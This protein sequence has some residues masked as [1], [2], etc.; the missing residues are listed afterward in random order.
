[1]PGALPLAVGNRRR[2]QGGGL[3]ALLLGALALTGCS[4]PTYR[5][6]LHAYEAGSYDK[7]AAIWEPL[8]KAG[9]MRAQHQLGN[10]YRGG[11]GV[12]RDLAR[13]FRWMERAARQGHAPSQFVAGYMLDEGMG[14]ARDPER[15]FRWYRLAASSLDSLPRRVEAR[16]HAKRLGREIGPERREAMMAEVRA[17]RPRSESQ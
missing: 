5:D 6:G 4:Q 12:P 11:L 14:V 8:A 7:A 10:L 3:W 1:M 15:A 9:H 13:S 2:L 16:R 17:F